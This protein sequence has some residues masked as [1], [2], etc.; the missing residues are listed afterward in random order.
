MRKT[1]ILTI[2]L[3]IALMA[4]QCAFA[5]SYSFN[6]GA[7]ALELGDGLTAYTKGS[8]V[9]GIDNPPGDYELLV[10]S[11]DL[12][13][14]W[15]FYYINSDR[16]IDFSALDD[17]RMAQLVEN[18]SSG[19]DP[20]DISYEVY[21]NGSRYLVVDSY[22]EDTDQY[23]HFYV[24]G[25]G[26]AL[27]YFAAPTYGEALT[28]EQKADMRNAIDSVTYTRKAAPTEE[29]ERRAATIRI[30]KRFGYAFGALAIF[31][32]IKLAFEKIREAVK[33]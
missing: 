21:D 7:V 17:E 14:Y 18:D 31:I 9:P 25:A 11:E 29:D 23:V 24:T 1:L 3:L 22:S 15:Y 16:T 19:A 26:N 32:V 4:P 33:K 8:A 6:D 27:Y 13:Y 10:K 28:D 12:G 20:D 5:E 2:I 30:M